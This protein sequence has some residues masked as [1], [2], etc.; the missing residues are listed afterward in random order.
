[1]VQAQK[2]TLPEEIMAI[3]RGFM[4]S[5]ALL[6][7]IELDL[8][9]AIRDGA[10]AAQAAEKLK[11]DPRAM[12]SLLNVLVAMKLAT[13]ADGVFR[14]TPNTA[15]FL[16]DSLESVRMAMMHTAHLWHSWSTLTEAVRTGTSVYSRKRTEEFTEAFISA[17][18]RNASSRAAHVVRALDIAHRRRVLDVGGGSGAY[19]IAFAQANPKLRAVVFDLGPV[20]TIATR[21]ID[22]AGLGERVKVSVGDFHT[23]SFGEGYDMVFLSAIC[24]MNSPEENVALLKKAYAA[25]IP[26]G[27]VVIQDYLLNAEKTAPRAGALFALNMLVG[28]RAGSSYSEPEYRSWLA[29]AGFEEV[30]VVQ[31]PGP[32]GLMTG[33]RR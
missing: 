10:T 33:V 26:G 27:E 19:S 8:F 32:T 9:S 7:A 1:M 5:R 30:K 21:H 18:H 3:S 23:D 4:E 12:E 20:I 22:E 25:L 6:T 11:T 24:H 17:M 15:R 13:K 31:L 2:Q 29:E 16:A 28:T 14:A